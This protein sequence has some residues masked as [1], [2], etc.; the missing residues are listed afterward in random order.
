MTAAKKPS[1]Q[2]SLAARL[3]RL[4]EDRQLTML[5]LAAKADVSIGV[6]LRA[7]QGKSVSEKSWRKLAKG[8]EVSDSDLRDATPARAARR[9]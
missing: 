8:L 1:K 5:G 9:S 2:E 6:V 4:R 7:E 3:R